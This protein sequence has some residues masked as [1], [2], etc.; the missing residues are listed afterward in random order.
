MVILALLL[1]CGADPCVPA[2]A[3]EGDLVATGL[4]EDLCADRLAAGVVEY[5]PRFELWSDGVEKR[6]WLELPEGE[7]IDT[8]DPDFWVFPVGTR[9][10]KEFSLDGARLETRLLTRTEGGWDATTY[11]WNRAGTGAREERKG[12]KDVLGTDHD[13]PRADPNGDSA[14]ACA[15]C[16]DGNPSGLLGVGLVQLDDGL[17]ADLESEGRFSTA[18]PAHALPGD[19][20]EQQALGYLHANCGNCHNAQADEP[21]LR[22]F[23][24]AGSLGSV[25][26][27][28]VYVTGVG[29]APEG[30]PIEGLDA[31]VLVDPGSAATSLLYLRMNVRGD[32]QMPWLA[33]E[34]VD[35]DGVALVGAFIDGL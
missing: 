22:L 21:Q 8:T 23:L 19:D 4:Y 18:L 29:V 28:P 15:T 3:R 32:G 24:E 26:E 12:A 11:R 30:D 13:V 35:A 2:D 6:R 34:Q 5:T 14:G 1:G 17:L 31:D 25:E 9:A 10:W 7:T 33:T 27:T 16:H 20:G